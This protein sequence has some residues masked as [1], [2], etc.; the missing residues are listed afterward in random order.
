VKRTGRIASVPVGEAMLGRVVNA[1]GEPIDGRGPISTN[2]LNPVER[3]APGIVDRQPV[4]E[5]LQTGM[6][7]IDS[8]VPI[9]RGQRELIIGDRQTGK[10]AI[11]L[12]TIINQKQHRGHLHIR[13]HRS[14][15]VDGG[16]RGRGA[17][18]PGRD[19]LH[20]RRGGDGVGDGAHAVHRAVR[21]LR[22]GRVF[23]RQRQACAGDLRRPLEARRCISA[24]LAAAAAS[25]GP[26]GVSGRR[27]LLHSR[28]LERAAKLHA[29]QGRRQFDRAA[30]HR[31][32]G[33]RRV[34]VHSDQ[35][36]F[37]HGRPD[38][39]RNESCST[40]ACARPSTRAFRC[41]AWAARRRSR[42]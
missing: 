25:A 6:K 24:T 9:G 40:R 19:G 3:I 37:D 32:A 35:R 8:M 30:D 12:D 34:R 31:N 28:L 15:A 39:S 33:R 1:L 14:K 11:A 17:A 7:A 2:T 29:T 42:R 21:R 22:L 36:H 4:H 18:Q 27:V 20:D 13:G 10:T 5:P 26:R 23:P 16:A 38:L 41:R